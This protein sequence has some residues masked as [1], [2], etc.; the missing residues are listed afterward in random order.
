[1]TLVT[2]G[3][4]SGWFH[5]FQGQDRMVGIY[6]HAPLVET[7]ARRLMQRAP[8]QMHTPME[9]INAAIHIMWL[10]AGGIPDTVSKC[11]VS[12]KLT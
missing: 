11:H 8:N 9:W 3:H 5:L 12:A 1:M 7:K 6:N 10:N 2:L 4:R